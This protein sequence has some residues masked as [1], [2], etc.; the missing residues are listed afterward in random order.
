ML[1][2]PNILSN[3]FRN[4]RFESCIHLSGAGQVV[5]VDDFQPGVRGFES[6]FESPLHSPLLA[7]PSIL[8]LMYIVASVTRK[9]KSRRWRNSPNYCRVKWIAKIDLDMDIIPCTVCTYWSIR[10]TYVDVMVC[11]CPSFAN[12]KNAMTSGLLINKH[13]VQVSG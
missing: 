8:K 7:R 12:H 13:S 2:D 5:S 3:G 9:P 1:S 11:T 6:H 4:L 10:C